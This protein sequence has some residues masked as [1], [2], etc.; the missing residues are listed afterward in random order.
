MRSSPHEPAQL[1]HHP[2]FRH[3][4]LGAIGGLHAWTSRINQF[5]FFARTLP[6]TFT[7]TPEA[8]TIT[9]RYLGMVLISAGLGMFLFDWLCAVKSVSL[10]VSFIT[11]LLL[12][13]VGLTIAFAIA[14]HLAGKVYGTFQKTAAATSAVDARPVVERAVSV[15]LLA[16]T[17]HTTVR[18][19][20]TPVL[21]GAS[22]WLGGVAVSNYGMAAFA[23]KVGQQGGAVL[24]GMATGMLSAGT[25]MRLMLRYSARQR[26]PMAHYMAR[27]MALLS[28]VSVALIGVLVV[29]AHLNFPVTR[30]VAHA[31]MLAVFAFVIG[32]ALY[33]WS[34][35]N[36][37]TPTSAEQ[38]GDQHWRAGLF[39]YNRQDPALFVQRRSGPGF[40]LNFGNIFSWPLTAF[41]VADFAFIFILRHH[42]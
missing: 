24:L 5:F 37:F 13:M 23:D 41:V 26:T 27:I 12:E 15:P 18:R 14:H 11:A 36:H 4:R 2:V 9:Q 34:R 25:A 6:S 42:L 10:V 20:F 17:T 21:V 22:L 1:N 40:T 7:N 32:N 39:Y 19:M 16:A 35:N 30:T 33:M 8:K 31:V 28:W 3:D 38:N 29:T